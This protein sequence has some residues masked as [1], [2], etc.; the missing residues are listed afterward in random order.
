MNSYSTYFLGCKHTRTKSLLKPAQST[1]SLPK[2]VQSQKKRPKPETHLKPTYFSIDETK[3]NIKIIDCFTFYNDVDL[4][5]YRL[6]LLYDIVDYFIIV[7]ASL[8]DSCNGQKMCFKENEKLFEKFKDKIIH[9]V[10]DNANID[11]SKNQ[12]FVNEKM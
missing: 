8:T 9:I 7:E 12:Q 6:N 3:K 5:I 11:I 2:P 10:I 4:L 1:K